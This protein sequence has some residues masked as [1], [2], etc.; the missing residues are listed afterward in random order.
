MTR[1]RI[2]SSR[3][4]GSSS[5]RPRPRTSRR[6]PSSPPARSS[7]CA[8]PQ[9]PSRPRPP[10]NCSGWFRSVMA[11]GCSGLA[12]SRSHIPASHAKP[13]VLAEVNRPGPPPA[14]ALPVPPRPAAPRR[15]P[16][17]SY[18]GP[19]RV[20]V[21]YFPLQCRRHPC[22]KTSAT[23]ARALVALWCALSGVQSTPKNTAANA[24]A[25]C[26]TEPHPTA[27]SSSPHLFLW[28][29]PAC[30]PLLSPCPQNGSIKPA[31]L[32]GRQRNGTLAI[33]QPMITIVSIGHTDKAFVYVTV[34]PKQGEVRATYLRTVR[35]A[36]HGTARHC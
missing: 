12:L 11:L 19:A 23:R 17:H 31:A 14:P 2:F 8:V 22:C 3:L 7:R 28:S 9:L 18:I 13:T 27:T 20:P 33:V 36:R 26:P 5:A 21:R 1:S 29:R 10:P 4:S 35:C 16:P 24:A 34:E 6:L 30:P 32:C 25:L 15:R